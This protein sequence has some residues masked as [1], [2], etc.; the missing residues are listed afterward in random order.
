MVMLFHAGS[1]TGND[2]TGPA[3]WAASSART[4]TQYDRPVI[5]PENV[6]LSADD[7][8]AGTPPGFTAVAVAN[9]ASVM[10]VEQLVLPATSR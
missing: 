2:V 10:A 4:P 3:F 9:A 7:G 1:S 6:R 8:A 5:I